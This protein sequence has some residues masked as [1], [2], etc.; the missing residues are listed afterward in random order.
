M[1]NGVTEEQ[2]QQSASLSFSD[3]FHKAFPY[4]LA[5][6][7]SYELFW[8]GEPRLVKEYREAHELRNIQK[9]Q[10]FWVQGV[11]VFRAFKSVMEA[12]SYGMSGGKGSKPS[13]YPNEPIPFTEAEQKAATERNKQRTLKWVQDNQY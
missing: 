7:M 5:I 12:F 2:E 9:N 10:E 6:G 1:D 11:Y 8:F 13:E 3:V 4:Y